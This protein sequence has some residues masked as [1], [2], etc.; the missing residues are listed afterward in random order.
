[1]NRTTSARIEKKVPKKIDENRLNALR[2]VPKICTGETQLRTNQSPRNHRLRLREIQIVVKNENG[3][4][5][6]LS[7]TKI[8]NKSDESRTI[9]GGFGPPFPL[10]SQVHKLRLHEHE[11][12][13]LRTS[14]A[15]QD[16][17]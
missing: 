8:T 11:M 15:K 6:K 4:K 7:G 9:R 1:M 5:Q 3:E 17:D 10:K 2:F 14:R 13:H 12:N 16:L